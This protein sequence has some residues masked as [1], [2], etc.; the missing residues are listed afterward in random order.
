METILFLFSGT[1]QV[2]LRRVAMRLRRHGGFTLVELLV[3]IA[4]I[5][6]LVALLLPAIQAAREAARRSQCLNNLKQIGL[7]MHMYHDTRQ[8]IPPSRLPCHHGTWANAIWPYLEEGIIAQQWDKEKSYHY[9]PIENVQVQVAVYLCP[10]RRAPPQLSVE[11]DSRGGVQHRP[12]ALGDYAVSIGDG[13]EY[14]GDGGGTDSTKVIE[15]GNAGINLTIPNGAFRSATGQCFGFDPDFRLHG[16]YKTRL[17]FKNLVDGLSKTI[18]VGEKHVPES[19]PDGG[20]AFGRKSQQ[21][22]SIYNGDFHRTFARYGSDLAP[23]AVSRDEPVL[24]NGYASFGSWHP[25][26]CH[27]LFGDSST[28]GVSSSLD[29]VTLA[30]LCNI[31]DGAVSNSGALD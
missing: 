1:R 21:D 8:A 19:A 26:I 24:N 27:F 4:I 23:I 7:A 13:H 12:G 14:Q 10:T 9:Q 30:Q 29:V 2:N 17:K 15:G 28:R 22:N 16:A 6:I 18:L 20:S 31:R 3:V 25:G 11:G 5:G